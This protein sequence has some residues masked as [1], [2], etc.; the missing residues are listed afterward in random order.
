M[1][2]RGKIV[3]KSATVKVSMRARVPV[4]RPIVV[5]ALHNPSNLRYPDPEEYQRSSQNGQ[6]TGQKIFVVPQYQL[7]QEPMLTSVSY[8]V[9][10]LMGYGDISSYYRTSTS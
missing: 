3:E 10:F 7:A 2:N 6:S 4:I 8:S 9:L 5:D 1:S